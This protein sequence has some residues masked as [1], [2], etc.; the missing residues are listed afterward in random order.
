MLKIHLDASGVLA[1]SLD[2]SFER[3]EEENQRNKAT[4]SGL[5]SPGLNAIKQQQKSLM[6]LLISKTITTTKTLFPID[7]RPLLVQ[8]S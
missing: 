2:R 1:I 5:Q 8:A 6:G 7:E 3:K 4:Q